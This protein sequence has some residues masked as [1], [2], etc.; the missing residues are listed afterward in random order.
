MVLMEGQVWVVENGS[1]R[2]DS[3]SILAQNSARN[4]S[5]FGALVVDALGPSVCKCCNCCLGRLGLL[6]LCYFDT[7]LVVF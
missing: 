3:E 4:P 5:R 7:M 1:S 2:A 6:M